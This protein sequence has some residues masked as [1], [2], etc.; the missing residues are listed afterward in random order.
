MRRVHSMNGP[1]MMMMRARN[2]PLTAASRSA[3][4]R[5]R[6]ADRHPG[7]EHRTD[8]HQVLMME[9]VRGTMMMMMMTAREMTGATMSVGRLPTDG[10]ETAEMNV[11]D[12]IGRRRNCEETAEMNVLDT[13]CRRR[14]CAR[15]S[16]R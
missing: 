9:A 8:P 11:L 5:Q 10:R 7:T 12:T 16:E 15:C 2:T 14:N 3:P 1:T 4:L 13:T 6:K